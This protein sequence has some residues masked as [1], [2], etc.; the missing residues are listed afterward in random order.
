MIVVVVLESVIFLKGGVFD[1]FHCKSRLSERFNSLFSATLINKG[2]NT[3]D[4]ISPWLERKT[5]NIISTDLQKF[6]N[7]IS[8]LHSNPGVQYVPV[9]TMEYEN[10]MLLWNIDLV[11][12]VNTVGSKLNHRSAWNAA[13]VAYDPLEDAGQAEFANTLLVWSK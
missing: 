13:H 6:L 5:A 9:Y 12:S 4:V 10:T 1:A 2:S 11:D 8:E 3:S 7:I